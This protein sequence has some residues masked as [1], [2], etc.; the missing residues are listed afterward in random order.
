MITNLYKVIFSVHCLHV[1]VYVFAFYE[2]MLCRQNCK[3][4]HVV[5]LHYMHAMYILNVN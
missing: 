3:T 2:N 5:N 1:H 4:G